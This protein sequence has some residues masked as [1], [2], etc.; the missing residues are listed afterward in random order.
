MA[1]DDFPPHTAPPKD[2]SR[3]HPAGDSNATSGSS[4][5]PRRAVGVYDRPERT[6]SAMSLVI[7]SVIVVLV[8][9]AL[10]WASGIFSLESPD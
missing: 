8:V 2:P 10:L 1:T 7:T 6:S 9:V 4:K 3:A 5:S